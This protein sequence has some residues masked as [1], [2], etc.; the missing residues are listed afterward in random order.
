MDDLL[1]MKML[2]EKDGFTPY[3]QVKLQHMQSKKPSGTAVGALCV[4]IGA[5]VGAVGFGMYAA[6]K[7]SEARRTAAAENAGTAALL[8]QATEFMTNYM[9]EERQERKAETVTLSQ[10]ITDTISGQQSSALT[11]NQA[12]ELSAINTATNNVMTGLMT[13]QYSQNPMRVVRVSGQRECPCDNNC[14]G[15]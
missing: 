6:S 8:K 2:G 3:E 4:G 14:G 15:Y 11:A 12:A 7:A 13:G 9:K 1:K 10:T 5:A